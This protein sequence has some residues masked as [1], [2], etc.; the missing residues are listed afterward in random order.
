MDAGLNGTDAER[1]RA[2]PRLMDCVVRYL[3]R[4]CG[5]GPSGRGELLPPFLELKSIS[6]YDAKKRA[7]RLE[8]LS[9][10][11]EAAGYHTYGFGQWQFTPRRGL[12]Y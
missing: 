6:L 7:L 11:E 1:F 10:I 5:I 8:F 12:S 2:P 9:L 3:P 4:C